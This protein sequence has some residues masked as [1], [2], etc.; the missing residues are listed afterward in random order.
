V[1][2]KILVTGASGFIGR[3]LVSLLANNAY[4]VVGLSSVHGDIAASST[5]EPYAK[6]EISH[7]FHLAGS[8]FVPDSWADPQAFFHANIL[9]T[10]N[11]LEFCRNQRVPLTFVSAYIYG[12]PDTLPI[13]EEA[14]PRP[15]N[16][17][18]LSKYLAEEACRH[19]ASIH[20][21]K[22][23]VIRP[24][25]I[26]GVGQNKRF[27]IPSIIHQAL[28]AETITVQDISPGRDYLYL[29]DLIETLIATLHPKKSFTVYNIG[30]GSSLSVRQVIDEIQ[31]IAGTRK[32]VICRNNPRPNEIFDI[33]ADIS[34]AQHELDWYPRHTFHDGIQQLI[35]SQR[36]A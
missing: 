7:I 17:Y 3:A 9:G 14:Q 29:D 21:L 12:Q 22:I 27:L 10:T 31:K 8:T 1:N 15:N 19:Y 33:V 18:A 16:P 36:Q 23:T 5:L 28:T 20:N 24:F 32:E 26:Y 25:N 35:K 6:A 4:E 2:K 11:I 13:S 30:S 34:K